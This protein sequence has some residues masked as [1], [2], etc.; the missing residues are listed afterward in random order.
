MLAITPGTQ[1][2]LA[3]AGQGPPDYSWALGLLAPT[4]SCWP[5][6]SRLVLAKDLQLTPSP[7]NLLDSAD[8]GPLA[9]SW[10]QGLPS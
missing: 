3:S 4:S 1:D 8:Q 2:L 5:G 10:D 9:Y 7:Q 6:T